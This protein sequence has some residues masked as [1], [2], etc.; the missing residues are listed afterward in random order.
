MRTL[1]YKLLVFPSA[2]FKS[3]TK[4]RLRV[5][6]YHDV[7]N[8]NAFEAHIK[9]LKKHFNIITIG[10]VLSHFYNREPLP[11]RPL[12]VTFDDGDI[13]VLEK[14]LPVLSSHNCPACVFIITGL[15]NTNN[16][17]WF[18]HIRNMERLQGK[19][20]S[21]VN[22]IMERL[23]RMNNT[24]R[25]ESIVAYGV[26]KREQLTIKDLF[27]LENNNIAITNHSHTHPMFNRC[28]KTEIENELSESKN[29]F[30]SNHLNGYQV[31][32]Y[33]NGNHDYKSEVL[34]KEMGIKLAFL[35]DHKICKENT[36]PFRISRIRINSDTRL[37]EFKVKVSGLH[38]TL[39]HLKV[40]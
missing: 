20:G 14:A 1:F 6:A 9:Y 23:K 39:L 27:T 5:L 30:D 7:K 36:N 4:N 3:V 25:L 34:L 13:S 32:A 8:K 17:F 26:G 22:L 19:G 31:F 35:F 38:S 18:R 33:P 29:F 21:E 10:D 2:V 11:E 40:K 12:L 24:N 16:E 28:S 15:I 37:D